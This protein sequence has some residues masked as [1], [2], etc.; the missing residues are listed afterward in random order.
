MPDIALGPAAEI[1]GFGNGAEIAFHLRDPSD[2]PG[3]AA[4]CDVGGDAVRELLEVSGEQA[5]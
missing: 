4:G 1:D 3:R 5:R 2:S